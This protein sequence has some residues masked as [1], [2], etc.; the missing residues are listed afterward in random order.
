MGL[1][2]LENWDKRQ[3][4]FVD[5]IAAFDTSSRGDPHWLAIQFMKTMQVDRQAALHVL[6]SFGGAEPA[7][8]QAFTM[9]TLVVCGREDEDNLPAHELADVCPMRF[10]PRSSGDSYEFGDKPELG[11]ELPAS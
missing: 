4:F 11:E 1:R 9:R 7:W 2:G 6:A 5:A 3:Q 10:S 8:L